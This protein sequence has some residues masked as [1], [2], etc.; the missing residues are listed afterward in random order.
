MKKVYNLGPGQ[1]VSSKQRVNRAVSSNFG[2]M[3]LY[4]KIG[5]NDRLNI[6]IG[7]N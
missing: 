4:A 1:G 3:P 7:K 5:K 6:K 2:K